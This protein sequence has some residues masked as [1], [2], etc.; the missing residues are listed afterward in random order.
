MALELKI[1]ERTHQEFGHSI[2]KLLQ[3][4]VELQGSK[5]QEV[6]LDFI[7]ARM[8]NPF[9]LGGLACAID[10][11]KSKGRR[12]GFEYGNNY[13]LQS[14]LST[15]CF[16]GCYS[17]AEK[18]TEEFVLSL[19]RFRTKT[20]I[21]IVL[22]PTG[23]NVINSKI[24][25]RILSAINSILRLQLN[26]TEAKHMP[27]SYMIDE[28]T[29]N[30]NDHS[31]AANGFIFV[32]YYP[33]SNYLDV[34]IC[35]HGVGIWQS[36]LKT[37]KFKPANEIEAVEFAINGRSTKNIPES[38]GFGLSTSRNML[39]NGLNGCFYLMTGNTAYM[40]T[41]A[42]K[43]IIN[44]PDDFYYQG[45]FVALRIPTFVPPEFNI[46]NYLE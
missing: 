6:T 10:Y 11:E 25:E 7:N 21:P 26:F 19:E 17:P 27:I 16:P 22:F 43:G 18:E 40:Q 34:C 38:K 28:M 36:Y 14:Y 31:D 37:D 23:N 42:Y 5:E 45:N 33:A 46:Y 15:I 29:H 8:L 41:V 13:G 35:D 44:L 1:P 9:F 32:Q 12:F 3:L 4:L 2:S 24:R 39:V 20:Y 30:V